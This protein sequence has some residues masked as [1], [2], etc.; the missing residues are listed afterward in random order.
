VL[1]VLARIE[2]HEHASNGVAEEDRAD[3]DL[4]RGRRVHVSGREVGD[5]D[6]PGA[7]LGAGVL[8]PPLA[9]S[10]NQASW[11]FRVLTVSGS[12]ERLNREGHCPQ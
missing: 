9:A 7:L 2:D 11:V 3:V 1:I 12:T 8:Y 6:A 4:E 5:E 10:A